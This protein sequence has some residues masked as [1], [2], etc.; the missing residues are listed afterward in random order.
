MSHHETFRVSLFYCWIL[1]VAFLTPFDFRFL[2]CEPSAFSH[3]SSPLPSLFSI[4]FSRATT[5][6]YL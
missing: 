6:L 3:V 2:L 1:F 4:S 5:R